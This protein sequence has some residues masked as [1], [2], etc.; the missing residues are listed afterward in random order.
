MRFAKQVLCSSVVLAVCLLNGSTGAA[1]ANWHHARAIAAAFGSSGLTQDNSGATAASATALGDLAPGIHIAQAHVAGFPSPTISL[2]QSLPFYLGAATSNDT[3]EIGGLAHS[4]A[5][6]SWADRMTIVSPD[7]VNHIILSFSLH[8]SMEVSIRES[9]NP[10]V[11]PQAQASARLDVWSGGFVHPF[12]VS[13]TI[14][15]GSGPVYEIGGAG[16]PSSSVDYS[17]PNGDATRIRF[18][19]PVFNNVMDFTVTLQAISATNNGVARALFS[20]TAFLDGVFLADGTT[21]E[22]HGMSLVFDSGVPSPNL[23][24]NAEV[25]EP[26]SLALWT[27][28]ALGCAASGYRR[29]RAAA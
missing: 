12:I 4:L 21:P 18:L 7:S 3:L 24:A 19:L 15:P 27:L 1:I 11:F 9:T 17:A 29:R 20:D 6:A 13:Q 28:A 16:V 5:T 2:P 10:Q 25:P 8:G 14:L 22:S 23:I 26:A